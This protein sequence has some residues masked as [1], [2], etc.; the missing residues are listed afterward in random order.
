M[1]LIESEKVN[2]LRYRYIC[3]CICPLSVSSKTLFL[4]TISSVTPVSHSV[5]ADPDPGSS[6]FLFPVSGMEKKIRIRDE[7]CRSF[8]STLYSVRYLLRYLP[9]LCGNNLPSFTVCAGN[10]VSCPY[11][12]KVM[13]RRNLSRHVTVKHTTL[14]PSL[15]TI[16]HKT[17]KSEWS[18]KEH[19][20]KSH[21][22]LQSQKEFVQNL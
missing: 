5:V 17:M 1:A 8:P 10:M 21:G 3:L 22:I 13:Y 6:A 14:Q 15:C 4:Y 19:E 2:G 9:F 18:L 11:C 7:H 16:C 12:P 20:R